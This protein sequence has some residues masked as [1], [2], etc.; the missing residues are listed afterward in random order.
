MDSRQEVFNEILK[1]GGEP[2]WH[3]SGVC[4]CMHTCGGHGTC[5]RGL[6]HRISVR[7]RANE[8]RANNSGIWGEPGLGV[9]PASPGHG[10]GEQGQRVR[11]EASWIFNQTYSVEFQFQQHPHVSCFY[12]IISILSSSKRSTPSAQHRAR[13]RRPERKLLCGAAGSV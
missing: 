3:G 4:V 11:R 5:M 8:A 9:S 6:P 13:E 1:L 12:F 2:Q 10:K 7:S